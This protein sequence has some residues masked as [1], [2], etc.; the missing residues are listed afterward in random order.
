MK[1]NKTLIYTVELK[2]TKISLE[3]L[4]KISMYVGYYVVSFC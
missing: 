2:Q 3:K 4:P 1:F